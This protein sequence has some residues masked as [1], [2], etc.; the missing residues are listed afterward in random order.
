RHQNRCGTDLPRDE[1]TIL[2]P[3]EDKTPERAF[4]SKPIQYPAGVP[5]PAPAVA[6]HGAYKA[7][8]AQARV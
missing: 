2:G 1:K 8:E 4:N 6:R 7:R 5:P 3:V